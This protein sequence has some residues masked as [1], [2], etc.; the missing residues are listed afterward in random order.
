MSPSSS[1]TI[2]SLPLAISVVFGVAGGRLLIA[3]TS[4]SV[5]AGVLL[6]AAAL[7]AAGVALGSLPF[8]P[9]QEGSEDLSARIGL[10]LL[11]G[12]LAGLFHGLLTGVTGW[13]D[14]GSLLGVGLDSSLTAADWMDRA[15]LGCVWGLVL[16]LVWRFL[17]GDTAGAK[18]ASFGL[19]LA[20]WQLFFVYPFLMGL[21]IAGIEVGLGLTPLVV[22]GFVVSGIVAG[23]VIG[24][25]STT[26]LG[27]VGAALV[28]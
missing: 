24:W 2:R 8:G 15:T 5:S 6:M 11:G 4:T 10:G 27:S 13:L 19:L 17:P 7:G 16:G 3:G 22:V 21:G 26:S 1:V 9:S 20:V 23:R 14:I 25:G 12:V 28:E 18:G